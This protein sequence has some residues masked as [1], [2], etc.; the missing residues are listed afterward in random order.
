MAVFPDQG[1]FCMVSII[2][3]RLSGRLGNYRSSIQ[4]SHP[5]KSHRPLL[6]LWLVNQLAS[7]ANTIA[8]LMAPL[9]PFLSTKNEFSWS[10][11][12]AQA[13]PSKKANGHITSA[14]V[15]FV[16]RIQ[17]DSITI[18]CNNMIWSNWNIAYMHMHMHL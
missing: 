12:H 13:F 14:I 18:T 2:F 5:S 10:E 17:R 6:F 4:V 15:T 3:R 11:H 1:I 16:K 9:R 8:E 7:G